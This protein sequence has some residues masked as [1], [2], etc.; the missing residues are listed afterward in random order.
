M[1]SNWASLLECILWVEGEGEHGFLRFP[2]RVL[3]E[4]RVFGFWGLPRKGEGEVFR[5][6]L[7]IAVKVP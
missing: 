2:K 7:K 6:G 5:C 3:K 1:V 4:L